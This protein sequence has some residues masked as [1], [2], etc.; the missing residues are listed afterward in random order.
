MANPTYVLI[1]SNTVGAGG[2]SSVTFSSI[3]ATYTD[4]LVKMSVRNSTATAD[5]GIFATY[6]GDA[7]TTNYQTLRLYGT[8]TAVASS[9]LL[10]TSA[11]YSQVGEMPAASATANTFSNAEFYIPNYISTTNKSISIDSGQENN[12]TAVITMLNA[13]IYL[14]SSAISSISFQC[15]SP[16]ASGTFVQYSTFYLYG[17]KNS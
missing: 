2:A 3:P 11:N 12:Q 6:N 15:G 7:I 13:G 4:L 17:I 9:Y 14:T 5:I 10:Y 1:A 8:G 16:T